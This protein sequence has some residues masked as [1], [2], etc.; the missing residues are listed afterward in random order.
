MNNLNKKKSTFLAKTAKMI[1]WTMSLQIWKKNST[2]TSNKKNKIHWATPLP[3]KFYNNLKRI[4][5]TRASTSMM[6][7]T[8]MMITLKIK[9]NLQQLPRKI[10]RLKLMTMQ[11]TT[12]RT[13]R[14]TKILIINSWTR[15]VQVLQ[16]WV[17][18]RKKK[19]KWPRK[20]SL[21]SLMLCTDKTQNS[22]PF[23]EN[24]P[25]RITLSMKNYQ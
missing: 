20:K 11:I 1:T 5:E 3:K 22:E 23:L 13:T 9:R 17:A 16:E 25:I 12:R 21:Q 24:T 14:Q 10:S 8:T 6:T 19:L 15:A 4:W 2:K 18:K 7:T